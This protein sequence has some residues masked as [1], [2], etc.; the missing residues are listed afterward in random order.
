MRRECDTRLLRLTL[1]PAVLFALLVLPPVAR[2]EEPMLAIRQIGGACAIYAV[3]EI[4]QVE[5]GGDSLFVVDAD[6]S[7][8]YALSSVA[9]IEFL[10]G[11][12]GVT[13][14]EDAAGLLKV[15]HLFQNR[16]NPFIPVTRIG[17]ELAQAGR[18][19][20]GIFSV[21]GRLVRTLVD[22]ERAVGSHEVIWD[23]CDA[24]GQRAAAGAYFYKLAAPGIEES[25]RMILLP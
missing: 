16:P 19:E 5:F 4:D 3:S 25:R 20:L 6:G 17:F 12:S 8:S 24:Q 1:I 10:W 18:V 13:D 7:D 14:P 21:D 9:R 23:G 2:A 15:M 11:F 22:E